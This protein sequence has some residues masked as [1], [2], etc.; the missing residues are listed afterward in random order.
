MVVFSPFVLILCTFWEFCARFLLYI[1]LFTD[2]KKKLIIILP[3][4]Q[5]DLAQWLRVERYIG[6]N[7]VRVSMRLDLL[8][9][10]VF[11]F[12]FWT[13]KHFPRIRNRTP[14]PFLS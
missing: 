7:Q 4:S 11:F 5:L 8:Q 3:R 14:N 6:Q 13:V 12:F 2:K 10:L 1:L 9:T